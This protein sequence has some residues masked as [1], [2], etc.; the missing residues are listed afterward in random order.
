MQFGQQ[1]WL[2]SA[3]SVMGSWQTLRA[4]VLS[5]TCASDFPATLSALPVLLCSQ[6]ETG[7][8]IA[9]WSTRM[10]LKK[11]LNQDKIIT[12]FSTKFCIVQLWYLAPLTHQSIPKPDTAGQERP[13]ATWS[14]MKWHGVVFVAGNSKES[15]LHFKMLCTGT[16]A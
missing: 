12:V 13:A 1:V 11:P 6:A 8:L 16:R 3:S 9:L 15:S 4:S 7:F 14:L 10:A 2:T 5:I